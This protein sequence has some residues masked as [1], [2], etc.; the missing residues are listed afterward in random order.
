M[1]HNLNTNK[2]IIDTDNFNTALN[3]H[4]NNYPHDYLMNL[5]NNGSVA[6]KQAA[7]LKIQYIRNKNDADI[8]MENL[9][10]CDGKIREAVSFRLQEFILQSP[11][12]FETYTDIFLEAIID[13]NG[14]ICRNTLNAIKKLKNHK[15]FTCE[16]SQKLAE[17]T[18]ELAKNVEK[19]N[20]QDGKYKINKEVFK[21][22]WSLET[23]CEFIE[24]IDKT[25]IIEILD[26][27]KD[28][29]DYTIREKTAK[30]IA[31]I[32]DYP[33]ISLICQQLLQDQNYYVRRVLV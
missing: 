33:E 17:K 8:F 20:L 27:T 15:K 29:N 3:I 14:N 13:I 2:E 9:T 12:L 6:Q 10:G 30:I 5:L 7:A 25:Q 23:T 4:T 28:I 16:F 32:S 31:K 11:E 19:I 24:F 26:I 18:L 21:L 1:E 22:Y